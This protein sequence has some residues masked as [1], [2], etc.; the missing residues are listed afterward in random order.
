MRRSTPAERPFSALE[1]LAGAWTDRLVVING[2]DDG[3]ARR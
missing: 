1:K 3:G 2:E